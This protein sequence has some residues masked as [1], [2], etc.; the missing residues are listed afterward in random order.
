MEQL[1]KLVAAIEC[2]SKAKAD[3]ALKPVP[4][5]KAPRPQ[6]ITTQYKKEYRAYAAAKARCTN[7]RHQ[8]WPWYGGRG[9]RFLFES[10]RQFLDHIGPCPDPRLTLGRIDDRKPYRKGNVSW[11]TWTE[12]ALGRRPPRPKFGLA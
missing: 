7:P 10:F 6:G 4:V 11:Q 12:Q 3:A 5:P 8:R 2:G 1:R 9:V